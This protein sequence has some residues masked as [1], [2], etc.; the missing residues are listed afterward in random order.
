MSLVGIVALDGLAPPA[1]SAGDPREVSPGAGPFVRIA[2]VELVTRQLH[3]MVQGGAERVL[4][5]PGRHRTRFEELVARDARLRRLPLE[6]R[7]ADLP[8]VLGELGERSAIVAG[9]QA[10]FGPGV[11]RVAATTSSPSTVDGLEIMMGPAGALAAGGT[12]PAHGLPDERDAYACTVAS[13]AQVRTA[14]RHI[15]RNVSKKTSGWV[16]RNINSLLS[17][18]TSYVISELPITPNMITIATTVVGL[19]SAVFVAFGDA[20]NLAIGGVLFQL[21]AALDRVDG[22]IARSKFQASTRGAW[23]DTVGDNL[24]YL[25]FVAGL[26]WGLYR[27]TGQGWVVTLGGGLLVTLI[28]MLLVMYGYL[29]KYTD[30]GSLVAVTTDMEE[31]LAGENKPLVYR[32]LDKI[33]FVGKRDFFSLAACVVLVLG[34]VDVAFFCAIGVVGGTIAYFASAATKAFR[35]T[36]PAVL[37][38]ASAAPGGSQAADERM[39]L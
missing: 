1:A 27:V 23:I 16:S 28:A 5:L 34:R 13:R 24:T 20:L 31:R 10:F 17:I 38:A 15:F 14:K 7:Y 32:A 33:R 12:L 8:S 2:G 26:T 22:E 21:A 9:P 19:A 36:K 4:V 25:C 30:S 37:D 11:A 3:N 18:P 29:R 35:S 6:V 39:T